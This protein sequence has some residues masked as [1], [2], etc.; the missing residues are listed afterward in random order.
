MT[1]HTDSKSVIEALKNP[2]TPTTKNALKDHHDII[3][4]LQ[5][6]KKE[7]IFEIDIMYVKAHQD[8]RDD[9]TPQE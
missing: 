3:M 9:L 7:S 1:L 4:Q 2:M 5:K 6:M 8:N